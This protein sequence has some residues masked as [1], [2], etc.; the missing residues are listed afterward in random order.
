MNRESLLDY[1][2]ALGIE[3]EA[4]QPMSDEP[5]VKFMHDLM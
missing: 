3:Y 5:I 2:L 1:G 4:L